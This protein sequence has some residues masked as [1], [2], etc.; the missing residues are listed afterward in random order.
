MSWSTARAGG[1][2]PRAPFHFDA[3]PR[4]ATTNK[5]CALLPRTEMPPEILPC[6]REPDLERHRTL[7][8][9]CKIRTLTK[10]NRGWQDKA[11]FPAS[12]TSFLS[13]CLHIVLGPSPTSHR[14][15]RAALFSNYHSLSVLREPSPAIGGKSK[16]AVSSPAQVFPRCI[17]LTAFPVLRDS[18]R[19]PIVV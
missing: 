18:V 6:T 3:M 11:G 13:V 14:D 1:N 7:R 10:T 8:K 15:Q 4:R 19:L 17:T 5:G 12:G 9:S 2:N 16:M